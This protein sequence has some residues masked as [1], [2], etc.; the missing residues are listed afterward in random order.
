MNKLSDKIFDIS[1][2][3]LTTTNNTGINHLFN[4][5]MIQCINPLPRNIDIFFDIMNEISDFKD[6]KLKYKSKKFIIC[7]SVV[8]LERFK[9]MAIS[10]PQLRISEIEEDSVLYEW[11]FQS[12][13][14]GFRIENDD[15]ES[16]WYLTAK[17]NGMDINITSD[18]NDDNMNAIL[19][20]ATSFV[21]GDIKNGV[22]RPVYPWSYQRTICSE[23]YTG[24]GLIQ[25]I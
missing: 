25:R 8:L 3:A 10:L 21:L 11:C 16:Y 24:F 15:S 4:E 9:D 7:F 20:T 22:S 23:W 14:F 6:E 13:R 2:M 5:W 17:I 12:G 1:K 18:F 19:Y